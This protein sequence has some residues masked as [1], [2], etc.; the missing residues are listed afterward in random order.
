VQ[1]HWSAEKAF[2]S[3]AKAV[4]KIVGEFLKFCGNQSKSIVPFLSTRTF[5][6]EGKDELAVG[7]GGCKKMHP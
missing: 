3:D 7:S 2:R 4:P 5:P 1:P 6:L